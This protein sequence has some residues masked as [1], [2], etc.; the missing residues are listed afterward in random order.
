M[1]TKFFRADNAK[2]ERPNGTGLGLYIVKS[3]IENSGGS[4]WFVSPASPLA[5]PTVLSELRRADPSKEENKGSSFYVTIP[6]MG[7]NKKIGVKQL[8]G[9]L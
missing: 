1:F 2:N 8:I 7:M 9:S 4:I 3:I 5:E 6:I